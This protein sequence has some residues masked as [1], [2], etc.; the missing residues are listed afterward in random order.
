LFVK[1]RHGPIT[2]GLV[3]NR[4]MCFTPLSPVLRGLGTTLVT[5]PG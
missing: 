3:D 2:P 4:Q 5:T 1:A